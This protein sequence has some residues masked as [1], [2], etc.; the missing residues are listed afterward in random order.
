MQ[1]ITQVKIW[2]SASAECPKSEET[3]DYVQTITTLYGKNT[4]KMQDEE[5]EK[6]PPVFRF[7]DESGILHLT[8][9][10][11]RI[12]RPGRCSPAKYLNYQ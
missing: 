6:H 8:N 2:C 11:T 12:S 7:V 4:A 1:P 3:K 10:E 5:G 9:M